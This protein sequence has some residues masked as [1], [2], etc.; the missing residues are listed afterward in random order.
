MPWLEKVGPVSLSG[1]RSCDTS[2]FVGQ[3]PDFKQADTSSGA[4]PIPV[5]D[6]SDHGSA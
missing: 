4:G 2:A 6:G 3:R 1:Y 5:A